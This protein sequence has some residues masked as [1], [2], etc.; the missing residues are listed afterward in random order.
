MNVAP[1]STR[2]SSRS[3]ARSSAGKPARDDAWATGSHRQ[4]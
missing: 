4:P 3:V 2:H 1:T